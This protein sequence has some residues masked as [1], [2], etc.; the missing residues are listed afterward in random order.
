MSTTLPR[1]DVQT[2]LLQALE[3]ESDQNVYACYQCGKCSAACPF[4]FTPQRVM[5]FLQLGQ[6]DQA[7]EALEK[8]NKFLTAGGVF[9]KDMIDGFIDLK[10]EEV[11]QLR[12]TTHPL[13]FDMYYS[14]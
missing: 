13:E 8:D 11:T 14:L 2:K 12:M 6:V 4:D 10:M 3:R 9:S 1:A 5:R 7:L